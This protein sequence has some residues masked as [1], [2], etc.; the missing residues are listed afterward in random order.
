MLFVK[1]MMSFS[2]VYAPEVYDT[3]FA[4]FKASIARVNEMNAKSPSAVFSLNKFSDMSPE[5]FK[6]TI[7]MKKTIKVEETEAPKEVGAVNAP[8]YYDWRD[9]GAVTPVK[10]QEQCGSCWAFS[11]TEAV[12]SAWILAGKGNATTLAL[13]PQQVVDCDTT[14]DGCGGGEPYSAFA[15][16]IQSGG[17][18]GEKD[19]PY[20]GANGKCR[21]VKNDVVASIHNYKA[22]TS[23]YSESTLQTNLLA[24]GP[25]SVC[26]DASAWQHYQ[27]GVMTHWQCAFIN[28]L[29][30]CVQLVG[31]NSTSTSSPYWIVRN[32]WNTDWGV[33]G[34]IYLEMGHDT[35]GIAHQASWPSL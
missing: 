7:L 14:S 21:F 16:L 17:Q 3:K 27:S 18:E 5:E 19:Y 23:K 1:H 30:H 20:T 26:V 32:S 24:W 4:N 9:H 34:Y 12:E 29:D 22:A 31:Y 13:A 10:D 28:L 6:S 8:T 35:C 11:A 15:Y 2:K 25:L 33:E